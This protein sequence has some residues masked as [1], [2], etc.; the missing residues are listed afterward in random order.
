MPSVFATYNPHFAGGV[1]QNN[2]PRVYPYPRTPT[3]QIAANGHRL[4]PLERGNF[5]LRHG[6]NVAAQPLGAVNPMGIASSA[7]PPTA[8][9]GGCAGGC[10][11][12]KGCG[13]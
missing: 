1:L 2:K 13:K 6:S 3:Y 10:G 7:P 4:G 11:N 9:Q 5:F 8:S 12:C